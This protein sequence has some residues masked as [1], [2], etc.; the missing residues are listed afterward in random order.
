MGKQCILLAHFLCTNVKQI[1][2]DPCGFLTCHVR[3]D[4]TSSPYV[5]S[6]GFL[7]TLMDAV[8]K[9]TRRLT[10]LIPAD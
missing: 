6:A 9:P 4:W 2:F 3:D 8:W 10:A 7:K 5:A 1:C